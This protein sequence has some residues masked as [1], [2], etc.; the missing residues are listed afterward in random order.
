MTDIYCILS[1]N[2][3]FHNKI[4]EFFYMYWDG[5]ENAR[6]RLAQQLVNKFITVFQFYNTMGCPLQM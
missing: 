3:S 4:A 1:V 6:V 2:C 5:S